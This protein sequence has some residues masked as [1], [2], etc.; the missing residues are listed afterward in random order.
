[1]KSVKNCREELHKW[2]DSLDDTKLMRLYHLI[3]G[4]FGEAD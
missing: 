4:I 1:M 3:R 2:I